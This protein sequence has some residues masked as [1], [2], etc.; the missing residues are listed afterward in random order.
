MTG[1]SF[2]YRSAGNVTDE[3]NAWHERFDINYFP[4]WDYA[5]TANIPRLIQLCAAIERDVRFPFSFGAIT[6]ANLVT[7]DLLRTMRRAG[8]IHVNF[9]V[10]SGYY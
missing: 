5:L 6:R 8:L 9:G 2:R 1:R 7:R 4:C 3:I 10:E